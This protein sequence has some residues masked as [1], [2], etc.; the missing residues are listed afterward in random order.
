[1]EQVSPLEVSG[2]FTVDITMGNKCVS[3]EVTVVKGQGESLLGR[4]MATE[5]GVLKLKIPLN[6]VVD[7]SELMTRYKDVFT[8]IGKL[9][10]FQLNL[11]ID[12]RVQRVAQPLRRPAFSLR[13]KI[14]KKLMNF[15][16]KILLRKLKVQRLGKTLL[17]WCPSPM[18]M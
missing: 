17:W 6:S 15:S 1:M 11:H 7:Y 16:R 8:G 10:D 18:V 13:E 3:A 12:Q 9:K 4:E 14:E 2:T 5:L